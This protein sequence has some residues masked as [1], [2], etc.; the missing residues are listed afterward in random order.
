MPVIPKRDPR[1]RLRAALFNFRPERRPML[2]RVHGDRDLGADANE[3]RRNRVDV[4]RVRDPHGRQSRQRISPRRMTII[5]P[6]SLMRGRPYRRCISISSTATRIAAI[7]RVGSF[8]SASISYLSSSGSSV[9]CS[10]LSRRVP[11]VPGT[12]TFSL[13]SFSTV[14]SHG[15]FHR[16][17]IGKCLPSHPRID[18]SHPSRKCRSPSS[19]A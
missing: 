16:R 12:V 9:M 2:R 13:A 1:S 7:C 18:R 4:A 19:A 6:M 15:R 11:D 8:F 10:I 3:N 14:G 17:R 5:Q